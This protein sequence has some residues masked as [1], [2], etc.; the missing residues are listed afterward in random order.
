MTGQIHLLPKPSGMLVSLGT[1][2]YAQIAATRCRASNLYLER[3]H[4]SPH[5]A[6]LKYL[7]QTS[8][9]LPSTLF[10]QLRQ[11]DSQYKVTAFVKWKAQTAGARWDYILRY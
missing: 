10:Y 4:W 1:S 7:S 2:S 6:T 11:R 9:A 5:P 3:W 8:S